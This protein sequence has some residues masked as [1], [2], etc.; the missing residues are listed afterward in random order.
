MEAASSGAPR[1]WGA[2]VYGLRL[3]Y[4]PRGR[5]TVAIACA[6][7]AV[8]DYLKEALGDIATIDHRPLKFDF[9][10]FQR[11]AQDLSA[12]HNPYDVFL[13][14]HCTQWCLGG[15]IYTPLIAEVLRPLAHIPLPRAATVWLVLSHLMVVAT[16]LLLWRALRGRTTTTALAAML[17]AGLLYQ[18]LFENFSYVQ[19]GPLLLLIMTGSAALCLCS[20][21]HRTAL[22][23]ALIG[24]ATVIKVTPILAAPA[25]LPPGWARRGPGD[26]ARVLEGIAG[27]GGL[28]GAATALILLMLLFVPFT[29]D[30]FT[31][32]LPHIG[33][34]TTVYENKSFPAFI[35][36]VF[37][38]TGEAEPGWHLGPPSSAAVTIL[39]MLIFL[40]STTWVAARIALRPGAEI[41]ARAAAFAAYVAA[42]PIA[43]TITWRHH[44]SV[45]ILAMALL[46]PSLWPR[47]GA[48]SSRAARWLLVASYP[49]TYIQQDFAHHL[50][51]P[52]PLD[53]PTLLDVMRVVMIDDLNL[54][55]MVCLWLAC[56]LALR[57]LR[58]V[59]VPLTSPAPAREPQTAAA[60]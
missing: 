32:V 28:V 52:H 60:V 25:L 35:A 22:A 6:I 51:L 23:G 31:Q 21:P 18:P 9:G 53:H 4:V 38:F 27:I 37:E 17:A 59:R 24:L 42:M 55:G 19:I 40:G 1:P 30:F 7:V 10:Q 11:A 41:P 8:L 36:R 58:V 45:N 34:G 14:M 43:S 47:E 29:A 13:S 48:G 12:G 56:V 15:Y 26:R 20:A 33:G 54:F 46:L 44:V 39:G 2:R 5:R 57:G 3:L 50:A 49:L 16:A